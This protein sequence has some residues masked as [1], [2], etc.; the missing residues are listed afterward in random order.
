MVRVY[1]TRTT[2]GPHAH[3]IYEYSKTIV[4]PSNF[5]VYPVESA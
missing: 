3:G 4:E 5:N 1:T 2:F